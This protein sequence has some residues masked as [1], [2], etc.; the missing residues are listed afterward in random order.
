MFLKM[1]VFFSN[2]SLVTFFSVYNVYPANVKVTL[3][4]WGNIFLRKN[5]TKP[6]FLYYVAY[7]IL[8]RM[9]NKHFNVVL[10]NKGR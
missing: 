3:Q 2:A 7:N 5:E 4:I 6:K 8:D 9:Q 1:T 10:N